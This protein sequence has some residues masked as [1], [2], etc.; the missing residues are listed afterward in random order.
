MDVHFHHASFSV[1]IMTFVVWGCL[2][3]SAII[4]WSYWAAMFRLR[5]RR[6]YKPHTASLATD[7]VPCNHVITDDHGIE[8]QGRQS[9]ETTR[10]PARYPLEQIVLA[11]SRAE[12]IIRDGGTIRQACIEIGVSETTLLRWRRQYGGLSVD[13]LQRLK[14]TEDANASLQQQLGILE[15]EVER[16][17]LANASLRQ[18]FRRI[19]RV[20]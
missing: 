6:Q 10:L 7:S 5:T 1:T 11:L 17:E 19:K 13:Q 4:V 16:L 3:A 2:I 14:T 20:A 15:A 8:V 9:Q 18:E 12:W